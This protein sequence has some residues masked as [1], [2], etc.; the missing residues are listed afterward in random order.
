MK[1]LLSSILCLALII[2][3]AIALSACGKENPNEKVA[4]TYKCTAITVSGTRYT[5]TTAP[6]NMVSFF[7]TTLQVKADGTY[8]LDAQ[9]DDYDST[10]SY[11]LDGNNIKVQVDEEESSATLNGDVITYTMVVN[12]NG[13]DVE[14]TLECTKQ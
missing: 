6:D 13:S 1:K 12:M 3:G 7:E 5:E 8:I 4:G 11:T 14:V 2:T 10:G 9:G